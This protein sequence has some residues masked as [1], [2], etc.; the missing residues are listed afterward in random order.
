MFVGLFV[1][2]SIVFF[3]YPVFLTHS[4]IAGLKEAILWCLGDIL[5][6]SILVL[7]L[8]DVFLLFF[9]FLL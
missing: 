3:R 2:S 4:Q 9:L 8:F 7:S 5:S 6:W 1:L